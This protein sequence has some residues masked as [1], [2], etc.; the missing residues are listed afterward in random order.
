MQDR[1]FRVRAAVEERKEE[2][3]RVAF[4]VSEE[5]EAKLDWYLSSAFSEGA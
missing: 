2:V 1:G 4:R 3:K 5:D